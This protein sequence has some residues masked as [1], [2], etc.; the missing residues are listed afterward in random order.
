MNFDV[1]SVYCINFHRNTMTLSQKYEELRAS[2][3]RDEHIFKHVGIPGGQGGWI[4][5]PMN[6]PDHG[7]RI[8][9]L[10]VFAIIGNGK[11]REQRWQ[12]IMQQGWQPFQ[13][14]PAPEPVKVIRSDSPAGEALATKRRR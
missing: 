8:P 11:Q 4:V 13:P 14:E 5:P 6:D 10:R 1:K 12:D 2:L 3:R 9:M 7:S